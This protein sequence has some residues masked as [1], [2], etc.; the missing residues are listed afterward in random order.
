MTIHNLTSFSCAKPVMENLELSVLYFVGLH[1]K[2]VEWNRL[3]FNQD[4]DEIWFAFVDILVS[5]HAKLCFPCTFF[6]FVLFYYIAKYD[7]A[8][9]I[10]GANVAILGSLESTTL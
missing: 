10:A 2:A 1:Q 3:S 9:T 6:F 5:C 4:T 8:I 7:L